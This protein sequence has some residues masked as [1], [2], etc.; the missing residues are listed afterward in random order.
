MS[1]R[2]KLITETRQPFDLS[3]EL[4]ATI[5][6]LDLGQ[7]VGSIKDHGYGYVRSPTSIEFNDRLRKTLLRLSKNGYANMLLNKDPII[8]DV[9]LNPKILFFVFVLPFQFLSFVR[10]ESLLLPHYI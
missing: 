2:R 5:D 3:S 9:V 1:A 4:Q 7:T 6:E 8:E 10:K